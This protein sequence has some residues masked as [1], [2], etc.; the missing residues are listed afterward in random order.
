MLDR[1]K[2]IAKLAAMPR[3]SSG[4][5]NGVKVWRL[6]SPVARVYM[7]G[8]MPVGHLEGEAVDVLADANSVKALAEE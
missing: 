5:I 2:V 6:D 1:D 4:R 8:S 7:V 3:G